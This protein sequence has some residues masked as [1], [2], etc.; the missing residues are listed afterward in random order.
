M[1]PIPNINH[2]LNDDDCDVQ[3]E[4]GS[5]VDGAFDVRRR[6]SSILTQARQLKTILLARQAELDPYIA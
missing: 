2:F 1:Q 5:D 3:I 4:Y 6:F